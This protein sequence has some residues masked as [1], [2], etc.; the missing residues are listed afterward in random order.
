[1]MNIK[2]PPP[3]QKITLNAATFNSV[4]FKPALIN[5]IYGNNGTGKSTIGR[6]IDP[7]DVGEDNEYGTPPSILSWNDGVSADTYSVLIYNKR[8]VEANFQ[9][10]GNLKGVFTIGEENIETQNQ[11]TAKTQQ[12]FELDKTIVKSKTDKEGYEKTVEL[13]LPAFQEKCWANT[14][15]LRTTFADT[16][17]KRKTKLKFAERVLE[18]ANPATHNTDELKNLYKIAFDKNAKPYSKFN[19]LGSM[20]R[21]KGSRGN[22]LLAKSI[23]SS[24]DSELAVFIKRIRS[25]DWVQ[26]GYEDFVKTKI[27]EGDC[28]FC[29]RLIP[30]ELADDISACFAGQYQKD[31]DDL[32]AFR[33]AYE[34]D[35]QGFLRVLET[36]MQ[37]DLY[38]NF[39]LIEY[40][41]KYA[42]LKNLIEIN[43]RKI[44]DKIKEPSV[45]DV[46]LEKVK[47]ICD[48]LNTII[49][50]YN[51]QVQANND[52]L[53]AKRDKQNECTEKVWQ[54]IAF[55]LKDEV[56]TYKTRQAEL[57]KSIDELSKQIKD[58]ESE[59]TKL[60]DEITELNTQIVS[61]LPTITSINNLL[62]DS[63]FQGFWL[64]EKKGCTGTYEV[65]RQKDNT[66]AKG[67]SEGERNFIAFLYFYHLVRGGDDIDVVGRPK[68]VVIDD[69]VS[70]M[71]SGVL[72][73][74]STLG[75][76][77]VEVC[78][79]NVNYENRVV[80]GEYIKQLF[81]MTHN[82][83]F[84]RE[85]T[86]N[87]AQRYNTVSFFLVNKAS[88]VSTIKHCEDV[89]PA[90]PTE[91][92]N[93]NPVKNSYSALWSEYKELN[94]A[95]PTLNVI[96][97]ILEY[98][99]MQLCG[100]DCVN[101][102]KIVLDDNKDKFIESSAVE[103]GLPDNTK[104]QL[105]SAMLSYISANSVGH[106]DGLN[107][108]DDCT[109]ATMHKNV[110]KLIFETLQQEQHYNM[111]MKG[112]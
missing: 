44:D 111:M 83:Y 13:L 53:T 69:P 17:E 63:G 105:A 32:K 20:E 2:I 100:Y 72:F 96:R 101:I 24:S 81:V 90:K 19:S 89:N 43:L 62:H 103:G 47:S 98:Y 59:S 82:V 108:I 23:V 22:E 94:K 88:N 54:H 49:T 30:D 107:F 31:I 61:I 45:E 29:G 1:M 10:Y 99:F 37:Q 16:Q 50:A 109:D 41:D 66:V 40:N 12:K 4:D 15:E 7:K 28:P 36:N 65:V 26:Q 102:R 67:L 91:K 97:R 9:D 55:N 14:S 18:I 70:S 80:D 112:S 73:L 85:I 11:I 25:M 57:Q 64:R 3:I 84:H 79:N 78:N 74:V 27:A 58:S 86:Y 39:N 51:E 92:E 46:V 5:F 104:L 68:I 21:L 42:R 110:F 34:S 52:I 56:A 95:V 93:I 6:V 60:E 77:M 48:E 8:F 87:Q 106:I 35:M 38:P 76:E 75:R 71:D 33:E